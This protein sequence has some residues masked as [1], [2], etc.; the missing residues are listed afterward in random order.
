MFQYS[1]NRKHLHVCKF[2]KI[3]K[4]MENGALNN[5]LNLTFYLEYS[6]PKRSYMFISSEFVKFHISLLAFR[7]SS[8]VHSWTSSYHWRN[9][10]S[11]CLVE[12]FH[13]MVLLT[14]KACSFATSNAFNFLKSILEFLIFHLPT[15]MRG[16][17]KVL[18]Y[19]MKK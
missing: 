1:Y 12:Y 19:S 4:Y 13:Y 17:T 15:A 2:K 16:L 18:T 7:I 8:T 9:I 5:V 6:F 11:T 10:S 14:L 3:L